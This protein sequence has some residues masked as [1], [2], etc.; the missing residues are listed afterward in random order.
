MRGLKGATLFRSAL[1]NR[2]YGRSSQRLLRTGSETQGSQTVPRLPPAQP[3][4]SSVGTDAEKAQ[5]WTPPEGL[6]FPVRLENVRAY[7]PYGW[8]PPAGG[9]S[10]LP[11]RVCRTEKGNNIPVYRDIRGHKRVYTVLKRV[12]GRI[13]LLASDMRRVCNGETICIRP[14]PRLEVRGDYLFQVREWIRAL[15]F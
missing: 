9:F 10:D 1:Q 11:F 14:G 6:V 7:R 5:F 2:L 13:D 3:E 8:T 12:Y 15:G 4:D